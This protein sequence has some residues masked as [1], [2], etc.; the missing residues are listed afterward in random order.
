MKASAKPSPNY[1]VVV[2]DLHAG[3]H[4]GLSPTSIRLDGGR[5][6]T[7]SE[8]QTY[9]LNCWEEFWGSYVPRVTKGQP[10]DLVVNG[11]AIDGVHHSSTT[12][13][14]HNLT[15]QRR[16][17]EAVL[18]PV[19]AKA[20]RY[21]H[22]R[23]TEAHAGQSGADEEALAQSLGA[24]PDSQGRHARWE[25][26][27]EMP[28]PDAEPRRVHF[29]HHIGGGATSVPALTRE[30]M[31]M[32]TETGRWGRQ[33]ADVLIRGH[34]HRYEHVQLYGKRG[35][36]IAAICP[37]WQGKT[38]FGYRIDGRMQTPQFGGLI[39]CSG[40]EGLYVRAKVWSVE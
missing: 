11:D 21:Y 36:Q 39:V 13:I 34:Q 18:R 4:M 22:I 33:P 24:I 15:D 31:T 2:T 17:A 5:V 14:S 32:Y 7:A 9:L 19:V 23:G 29:T 20:A 27:H 37:G 10:W 8:F 1:T 3:C 16:I 12:Q 28:G 35:L 38:P 6:H 26:W 40:D 30:L 25:M